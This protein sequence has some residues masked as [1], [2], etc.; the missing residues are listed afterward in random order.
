MN[1]KNKKEPATN[2]HEIKSGISAKNT[3]RGR[4]QSKHEGTEETQ[5]VLSGRRALNLINFK[6]Y[7]L[8]LIMKP[9]EGLPEERLS[10]DEFIELIYSV[11]KPYPQAQVLTKEDDYGNHEYKL[12]LVD[13]SFERIEHLGTQMRF[14][15]EEGGGEAYY[16]LG[17]EDSGVPLGIN[18]E[19]V[20]K[21][22]R[23]PQPHAR[24]ALLHGQR[25]P[26]HAV[27]ADSARR[28]RRQDIQSLREG[29]S[30]GRHPTR[31]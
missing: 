20:Y 14:R 18:P 26:R 29:V 24:V 23:K 13:H 10:L 6:N 16:A 15:L 17:Y 31:S 19:D 11:G 3:K 1:R 9:A 8:T 25:N 12:K 21:S 22:F 27:R 28:P 30:K 2:Q 5:S 4:K 7:E